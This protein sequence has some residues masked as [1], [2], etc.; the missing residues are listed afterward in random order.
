MDFSA[1]TDLGLHPTTLTT[2]LPLNGSGVASTESV[3]PSEKIT[4]LKARAREIAKAPEATESSTLQI[5]VTEFR[6]GEEM[7]AFASTSVREVYSPKGITPLPCTPPFILGIINVRGR[8]LPLIDIKPLFGK[9]SPPKQPQSKV[10]IIHAEEMEVGLL[11][12][13]IVGVRA[14]SPTAIYPPL[15]TLADSQ[16]R[17]LRGITNDGTLI[18]DAALLLTGSRLS[19]RG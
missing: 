13:T 14:I 6:F 16:S 3:S 8:I 9:P 1:M 10:V 2:V 4:L 11:A 17:Y 12:D 18:L 7:Y 5:E 19:S 15:P